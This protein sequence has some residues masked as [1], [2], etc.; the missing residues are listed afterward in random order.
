MEWNGY[1]PVIKNNWWVPTYKMLFNMLFISFFWSTKYR[2]ISRRLT[3]T[4]SLSHLQMKKKYGAIQLSFICHNSYLLSSTLTTKQQFQ[5]T[6]LLTPI[7][8]RSFSSQLGFHSQFHVSHPLIHLSKQLL[9]FVYYI[10]NTL[11]FE[12]KFYSR[13]LISIFY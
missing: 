4:T 6:L 2:F 10:S 11:N 5:S 3:R 9:Y 1:L 8:L 13:K 12:E 7:S